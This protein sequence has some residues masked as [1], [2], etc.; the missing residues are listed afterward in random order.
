MP[1]LVSGRRTHRVS[2]KSNRGSAAT[3]NTNPQA[4]W[5][6]R[7]RDVRKPHTLLHHSIWL[8]CPVLPELPNLPTVGIIVILR[9]ESTLMCMTQESITKRLVTK[10]SR[11]ANAGPIR[12]SKRVGAP[13][14]RYQ[15]DLAWLLP[16]RW[17]I[18]SATSAGVIPLMRL[19]WPRLTGRI[20]HSFSHASAR[21]W[22]TPR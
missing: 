3:A 10:R 9:N 5:L 14:G 2:T 18:S 8:S 15:P 21:R 20:L 12:R 22:V 1:R 13:T 17:A 16:S 6:S 19:A 4:P 11:P 7:F